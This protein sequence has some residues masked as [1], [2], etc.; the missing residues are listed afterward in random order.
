MDILNKFKKSIDCSVVL[1]LLMIVPEIAMAQQG[2]EVIVTARKRAESIQD[3]PDA[4]TAFTFEDIEAAGIDDVA[5]F[6]E[7]TPNITI[8]ETFRAGVT[9]ITVRGISTGQQGWAPVTFVVDGVQASSLDAINQ[10]AL[11][12]LEQIE[13]LKG[14][15]GALYGAGAIAGAIN[16]TTK[17]PGDEFEGGVN[18]RYS[19]GNDKTISGVISGPIV[20][21]KLRALISGYYRDADGLIDA[22]DGR[23]LDFEEQATIRGRLIFDATDNLTFDLRGSYSDINAGAAFQDK[24][25]S[26]S[27]INS[28]S[29]ANA[30]GPFR[31][32]VGMENRI[33]T[34]G[35]LKIDWETDIGTFTSVS[36]YS[37]IMQS[38]FGSASWDD[39]IRPGA[40]GVAPGLPLGGVVDLGGVT[41]YDFFQEL[42]DDFKSFTQ[43]VR[44][45]SF[46]EGPFRWLMGASYLDRE[47]VNE[48][49]V[50][51]VLNSADGPLSPLGGFPRFDLK[52]DEAWGVY[53][54][55]NYDISNRLELTLAGRYD[56]NTYDTTQYSDEGLTAVV[57][58]INPNGTA[59]NTLS[60][61]DNKFQP[62]ATLSYDIAENVMGYVTYAE[63]FRYGFFNTGN[64]TLSESTKN[65]EAGIKSQFGPLTLNASAF[66]IDYSD[67][68]F[69]SV[70][71]T[72]PFRTT[73]NIPS[74][75]IDG[76]EIEFNANLS[77]NFE[78]FGGLGLLDA[79]Q[80]NG[81]KAQ[82]T[83]PLT[84]NLGG[85][86]S[87]QIG[88]FDL[89]ARL[90]MR[91]QGRFYLGFAED[92]TVS[93]KTY[94]NF[95]TS[96]GKN[97]WNIALFADNILNERQ[98]NDFSI[99]AGGFVRAQSKPAMYGL[100]LGYK[101]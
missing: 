65:Y 49:S 29:N 42:G 40:E 23:D 50:G 44:L 19:K 57:Q 7:L 74:T 76:I 18:L 30:P 38:L 60:N 86:Y 5:D 88:G 48:L 8:R 27:D 66:H 83:P 41:L 22:V 95:R 10:G 64:L 54:Q 81:L 78:L 3:V 55:I 71:A 6:I 12:D 87:G 63:G 16:I 73:T 28:F 37:E 31:G 90:D 39:P 13:V 89:D 58:T 68:Q 80:E 82:G 70:I 97:N 67:Q 26:A 52:N 77:D 4:V 47:V 20:E 32:I 93:S 2:D 33:L 35:A 101:F 92:F 53:G 98:A 91:E 25:F 24:V 61:T 43:D 21:G 84:F 69:T 79:Q 34:E 99:L 11:L 46:D 94:I 15:Q 14:P 36:G 9:F 85:M 1:G 96:L 51:F 56:E 45:T 75:T 100:E 62:K 17:K 59:V 72:P